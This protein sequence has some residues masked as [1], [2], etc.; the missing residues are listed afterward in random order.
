MDLTGLLSPDKLLLLLLLLGPTHPL[1]MPAH[2]LSPCFL[3]LPIWPPPPPPAGAGCRSRPSSSLTLT[4]P[5]LLSPH[6]QAGVV[7]PSA[8][9]SLPLSSSTCLTFRFHQQTHFLSPSV[10]STSGPQT[11]SP[12]KSLGQQQGYQRHH[13]LPLSQRPQPSHCLLCSFPLLPPP[14]TPGPASGYLP[15]LAPQF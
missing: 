2:Q 5:L 11:P 10:P 3:L 15:S 8:P 4:S 1:W 13:Q 9:P 7:T 6:P 12:P 14:P